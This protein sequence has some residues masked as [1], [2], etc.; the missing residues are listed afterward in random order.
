MILLLQPKRPAWT[1][2][3]PAWQPAYLLQ[4]HCTV[5]HAE[6]MEACSK[7]PGAAVAWQSAYLVQLRRTLDNASLLKA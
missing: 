7:L 6:L 5:D 4:L 1:D 3:L 2:L